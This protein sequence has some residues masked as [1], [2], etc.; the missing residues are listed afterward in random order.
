[1]PHRVVVTGGS[2]VIGRELLGRLVAGGAEVMSLDRMP[3]PEPL[4]RRVRQVQVDLAEGGMDE[5]RDFRPETVYHLAAAFERSEEESGF[6]LPGYRDN[7][8]VSHR[9]HD[10]IRATPSARTYVFASSYLIYEPSLYLLDAPREVPVALRESD[11]I[12]PRNLCGAAKLYAETE[13]RF[14][15]EVDKLPLRTVAAR[16]YR[17][18]GCGSRDVVSR[19]ARA[20]IAGEPI[21]VYNPEN[22]FDYIF[23][24]DVAEALRRLAVSPTASGIVNVATGRSPSIAEVAA[25]VVRATAAAPALVKHRGSNAPF[26]ASGGAIDRLIASTDWRPP[27]GIDAGIAQIV[28]H[29]RAT[30][31][32]AA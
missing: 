9:L 18:Y 14:M 21:E 27:T 29:E 3:L 16:I 13:M 24:G 32:R 15:T 4:A 5:I 8:A 20:L 6:W 1:M 31:R 10:T 17:V 12:A 2:G 30:A 28:A 19:W 23:A 25:A 22:R 11:P 26:E 7:I